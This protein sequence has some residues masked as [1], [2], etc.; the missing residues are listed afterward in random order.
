MDLASQMELIVTLGISRNRPLFIGNYAME[1]KTNILGRALMHGITSPTLL[2]LSQ[3]A[4]VSQSGH[5]RHRQHRQKKTKQ[6]SAL[7]PKYRNERTA[8]GCMLFCNS[9]ILILVGN[10]EVRAK[11]T[12]DL[13]MKK[14]KNIVESKRLEFQ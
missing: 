5:P 2:P 10:M 4:Q 14:R 9:V 7:S 1:R 11:A 12:W 13:K 6:N 3:T 8:S